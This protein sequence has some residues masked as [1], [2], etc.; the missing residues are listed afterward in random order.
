MQ[1]GKKTAEQAEETR[2]RRKETDRSR[3]K[4]SETRALGCFYGTWEMVSGLSPGNKTQRNQRKRFLRI[5]FFL[6]EKRIEGD[7]RPRFT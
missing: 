7:Q 6:V 3:K 5:I 2:L 1:E 4:L